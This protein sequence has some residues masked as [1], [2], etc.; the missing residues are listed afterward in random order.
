MNRSDSIINN[1]LK[2]V[3]LLSSRLTNIKQAYYNTLNTGLRERLLYENN[4]LFQRLTEITSIAQLLKE[5]NKESISFSNLLVEKCK[6]VTSE[7]GIENN[8]FFL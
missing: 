3:D 6:R 2:E 4:N 7:R 8:L 5:R 1:L